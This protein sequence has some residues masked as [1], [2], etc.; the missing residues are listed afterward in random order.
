MKE[1][2]RY[3]KKLE[4]L[5]K[6][7]ESLK[8]CEIKDELS[9]RDVFYSLQVCVE[10]LMDLVAMKVKDIGLIVEDDYTNIEKLREEE[11]VEV[12]ETEVL[13]QYNGMRNIIVHR[14]DTVRIDII[15]EGIANVDSLMEI[16]LKISE[17]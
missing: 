7:I 14:Y 1:K 2:Q 15:Q 12:N 11:V 5:E 4:V 6:E 16:G 10:V 17:K 9:R 13:K 3:M 8:G